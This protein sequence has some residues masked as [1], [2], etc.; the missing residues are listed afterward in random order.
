MIHQQRW[1]ADPV[2]T[3]A[4]PPIII[5]LPI[6]FG[7]LLGALTAS[8]QDG[9]A[10]GM[11]T[12][13]A[14]TFAPPSLAKARAHSAVVLVAEDNEINRLVIR[15]SS[16]AWVSPPKWPRTGAPLWRFCAAGPLAWCWPISMCR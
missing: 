2:E 12:T 16:I 4:R 3:G 11:R 8:A 7:P 9:N 14:L 10:S 6:H 13:K 1:T 5:P 15:A